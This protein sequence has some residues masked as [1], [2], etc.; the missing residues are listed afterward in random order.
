MGRAAGIDREEVRRFGRRGAGPRPVRDRPA[1]CWDG[2]LTMPVEVTVPDRESANALL[3][4]A[5]AHSRAEI[6]E[7]AEPR[8][9]DPD[10][11]RSAHE[12]RG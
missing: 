1:T 10:P 8:P 6:V 5:E 12:R 3:G 2:V 7:T 9:A 4:E 11:G